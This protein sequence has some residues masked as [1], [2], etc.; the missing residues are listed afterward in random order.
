[1]AFRA[2]VAR[3]ILQCSFR[4]GG[5]LAAAE[6]NRADQYPLRILPLWIQPDGKKIPSPRIARDFH[7]TERIGEAALES[8]RYTPE[9]W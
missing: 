5:G 2:P 7:V 4:Q 8:R 9:L 6:E 3:R 1:M